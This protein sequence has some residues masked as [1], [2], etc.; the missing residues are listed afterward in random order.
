MEDTGQGP[1]ENL[2]EPEPLSPA[3]EAEVVEDEADGDEEF[4]FP[5]PPVAAD[6]CIVPVYPIFGRPPS[7]SPRGE[8][9][10]PEPETATVRVPLGRL[11]LEEREFRARE[12]DGR[13]ASARRAWQDQEEEEDDDAGAGDEDLEGVP[14]ETY[15][16]WAPGGGGGQQSSAPASP[17]RCR[18]S[19]STGSVLRWRRISD[20][21]VGRSHSDGKE[22]FVFLTAAAAVPEPPRRSIKE[23]EEAGGG[24]NKG[25]DAGSV[26]NQLRYY[27]R[28]GGGGGSGSRRR[29]YLP[30]R[31]ELVGLFANVSGLRRSYH[32]F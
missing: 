8:V 10:E 2:P 9:E 15:C 31:Q 1:A 32:P 7:P 14:P 27:G 4:S 22:K 11:L 18:K 3:V 17:R 26:A 25:G 21:L 24:I 16:L 30:Y 20:R 28:G 19:G 13:S 23:E 5:A 12:Q 6:A 29:S